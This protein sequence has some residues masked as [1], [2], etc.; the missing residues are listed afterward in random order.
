MLVRMSNSRGKGDSQPLMSAEKG[1]CQGAAAG[2]MDGCRVVSCRV[3]QVQVENVARQ[4][5]PN[6]SS[7]LA[8]FRAHELQ[9][10]TCINCFPNTNVINFGQHGLYSI[11]LGLQA[12]LRPRPSPG[13]SITLG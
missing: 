9:V 7:R 11:T 5:T 3:V 12:Q 13:A 4:T 2:W 8:N 10:H 6:S 1:G